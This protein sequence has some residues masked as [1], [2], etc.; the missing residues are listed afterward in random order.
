MKEKVTLKIDFNKANLL[1]NMLEYSFNHSFKYGWEG[2]KNFIEDIYKQCK[3][4]NK[5]IEKINLD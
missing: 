4:Q 3:Q 5:F 2:N 1:L